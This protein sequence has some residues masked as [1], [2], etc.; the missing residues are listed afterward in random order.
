MTTIHIDVKNDKITCGKNGGH[1]RVPHGTAITW[2][3]S[4]GT[5]R[6][7]VLEFSQLGVETKRPRH[8]TPR[9]LAVRDASGPLYRRRKRP[10]KA[11]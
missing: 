6:K 9:G 5:G 2:T 10:S 11:P 4:E 7:F 1:I 8:A 3:P